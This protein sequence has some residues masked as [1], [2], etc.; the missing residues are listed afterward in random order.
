MNRL[1]HQ[2]ARTW[3]E[4]GKP[5]IVVDITHSRGSVPREAGT[6]MLVSATDSVGTVGG[7]QLE[8][9]GIAHARQM[10]AQR[11]DLRPDHFPHDR[12]ERT[13]DRMAKHDG[14]P[15]G[16]DG[17]SEPESQT[18]A[19]GPSLGQCCGGSV[20]LR[21]RAL[22]TQTFDAW[23]AAPPVFELQLYG[24]G[25][26]GQAIATL[27]AT[28]DVQVDWI[29][30]REA[31][32]PATTALGSDWPAHIRRVC[33]DGVHAEVDNARPGAFFLVLTHEHSLDERITEAILRRGDFGYLGLIGSRTKRRRFER[34]FESRG[35][36]A[37]TLARMTCP[38]GVGSI[39]D[40]EPVHI[41][42]A[43]VAQLLQ[44]VCEA[45]T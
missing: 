1:V 36:P 7:G 6:R 20:T 19:L 38:I 33:V 24:A 2:T 39:A 18:F 3:L 27:L 17:S 8:Y 23:P 12:H 22:D 37:A 15:P 45:R 32:F 40:K 25:H 21:W 29:D 13:V 35:I 9:R 44:T 34:R 31:S 4:Q 11:P 10:L 41:A 5:A 30:E 16:D 26:V 42:I 43:V 14:Q 28:L